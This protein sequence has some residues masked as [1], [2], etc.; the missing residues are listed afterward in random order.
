MNA[1]ATAPLALDVQQGFTVVELI[2]AMVIVALLTAIGIPAL[3]NFT[4]QQRVV[5]STR[6][7]QLDF[8][9]ARSEAITRADNVSV[10]T[11]SDGATCTGDPWTGGRIVFVDS[12]Q[13]GT[14]DGGDTVLRVGTAAASGLSLAAV[15]AVTFVNFNSRG[16]VN[17]PVVLSTCYTGLKGRDLTV[18]S[19][20]NPSISTPTALCP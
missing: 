6:D 2:V 20:G 19:T 4:L 8:V 3:R 17:L 12:N 13:S 15:P 18:R 10:C 11:S 5:T 16:Q 9:Y 7:L 14:V 1:S